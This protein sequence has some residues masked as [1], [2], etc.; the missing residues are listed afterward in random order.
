MGLNIAYQLKRRDPAMRVLVLEQAPGL[1]NGSSGYSTGFQRAFYS[2]DETMQLALDGINAYKNWKEYLQDPE[3]Q[4][5]FTHTGALWMLG[6]GKADNEAMQARLTAFGVKS[7]V[8][9]AQGIKEKYPVMNTDPFPEYDADGNEVDQN[10]GELTALYEDGCGHL[11]SS[12]CL[13]DIFRAAK[14][15]GVDIRFKQKVGSFMTSADGSRCTGVKMEDGT[16]HEAGMAVVNGAGPWF[17]KL[18]ATVGV[19]YST[20]A[21]PTRIQV[22]HKWIP[23]EYLD[24]PFVADG[25]GPSGIYFMPRRANNQLVFGSV[26]HRFESEIVDP[27]DYNTSLDPDVKQDYLNCLFHRL[28]G[29]DRSGDIVGFSSM[30][31][32][33]QEDVHPMIGETDLNGLWACNGF[34]GHGFKLAPAVG[35]LVAQQITAMKT[36][37]WETGIPLDFMGANRE[38]LVMKVKTHFA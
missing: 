16:V 6:K 9:D 14:R 3:A 28:P 20:T 34:S 4:A 1:G 10:L 5:Y 32:V 29:L 13:E 2:F 17:N 11:D 15:D 12:T 23:D 25:W 7:E 30:Y 8:L 24:L 18:N 19:T 21:L 26:A 31:T 27:D 37:M 22:G 38:P 36:N 35:S 33:N